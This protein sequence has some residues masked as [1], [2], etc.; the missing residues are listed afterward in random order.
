MKI[1]IFADIHDNV[2]NLRHAIRLFNA[3]QCRAVL[4]AG[5]FVS[6]LVVPSMRKLHCPVIACFGDN[7]GNQKGIAGGMTIVG[8]L[9]H[10]PL[11][12]KSADG[13]RFLICHQLQDV[14]DCIGDADVVV[15][16]HT[17]RPSLVRD[18]SG[19]LFINPG[20]TGGWMFRKPTVAIFDTDTREA[21]ILELPPMP[22]AVPIE[23]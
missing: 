10:P 13:L 15:F 20:E 17:H 4:L 2:D 7:D 12:W 9:A 22:P 3:M 8:T 1:G 23:E 11:C 16:A 21:D 14:R 19:R 5:D 6:P 18:R